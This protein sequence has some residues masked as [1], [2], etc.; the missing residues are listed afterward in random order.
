MPPGRPL[1]VLFSLHTSQD[2]LEIS[3]NGD[4]VLVRKVKS[5]SN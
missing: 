5:I 4:G 2:A 3:P 1:A